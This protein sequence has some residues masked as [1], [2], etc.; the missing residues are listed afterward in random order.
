MKTGEQLYH[1]ISSM[2]KKEKRLFKLYTKKYSSSEST[3]PIILFDIINK[4]SEY[5]E[6]TVKE[7]A[8]KKG[9]KNLNYTKFLLKK[10]VIQALTDGLYNDTNPNSQ[11]DILNKINLG[12]K[13]SLFP[14]FQEWIEKGRALYPN[15]LNPLWSIQLELEELSWSAANLPQDLTPIAHTFEQI[16]KHIEHLQNELIYF[17]LRIKMFHAWIYQ[18]QSE[19]TFDYDALEK[20][21]HTPIFQDESLALTLRGKRYLYNAKYFYYNVSRDLD[22]ALIYHQKAVQISLDNVS[23]IQ[24]YPKDFIKDFVNLIINQ[25]TIGKLDPVKALIKDFEEAGDKYLNHSNSSFID[26]QYYLLVA[27]CMYYTKTENPKKLLTFVP[28][29]QEY[30]LSKK[31]NLLGYSI[32]YLYL[33][34]IAAHFELEEYDLVL[35]WLEYFHK[36]I[37]KPS[38]IFYLLIH[39]FE[40]AVHYE[41][42]N[43]QLCQSILRK[44]IY[45]K[46]K[47]ELAEEALQPYL[48]IFKYMLNKEKTKQLDDQSLV[49]IAILKDKNVEK[50]LIRWVIKKLD[51]V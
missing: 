41:Q 32:P 34:F 46:Q 6:A 48:P 38:V 1:L 12:K 30:F 25:I 26:Y 24:A 11:G 39:S 20:L 44:I 22:K 14:L 7:Q 50:A 18:N 15:N 51:I 19:T 9:I 16:N 45:A 40:F 43:L 17:H 33:F 4:L 49:E 35:D 2:R 13:Y 31:Y 3:F 5:D 23:Y 8:K 37:K 47:Y 42:G 29:F 36:D 21:T 27:N 28:K 10:Q